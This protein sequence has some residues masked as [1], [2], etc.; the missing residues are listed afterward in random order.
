MILHCRQ[1]LIFEAQGPT[2]KLQA[3]SSRHQAPSTKL[4]I[5]GTDRG[6]NVAFPTRLA[7][8]ILETDKQ[9]KKLPKTKSKK[10]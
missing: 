5:F 4:Q 6:T 10:S 3:P 2:R 7:N 9:T 8:M 1:A